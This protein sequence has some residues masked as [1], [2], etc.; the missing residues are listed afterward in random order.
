MNENYVHP[1][2][3]KGAEAGILKGMYLL[4]H[5]GLVGSFDFHQGNFMQRSNGDIVIVDPLWG[6]STPYADYA[7]M[8][9][10]EIGYEDLGYDDP[11]NYVVGGK[12]PVKKRK[13]PKKYKP[14]D[15]KDVPF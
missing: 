7:A 6:G 10:G 4:K 12:L 15:P 8:M 14:I 11:K 1:D 13:R 9:Q 5:S 3:P 2:I